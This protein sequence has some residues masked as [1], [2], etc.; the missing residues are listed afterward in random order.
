ML[1][2]IG[3]N[4]V[5]RCCDHALFEVIK[6]IAGG[7]GLDL[8]NGRYRRGTVC[9]LEPFAETHTSVPVELVNGRFAEKT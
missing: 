2:N 7:V 9:R 1:N 3:I 8:A 5:D 4:L 6:N